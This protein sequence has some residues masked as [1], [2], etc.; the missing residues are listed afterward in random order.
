MTLLCSLGIGCFEPANVK[1]NV[2]EIERLKSFEYI[3]SLLEAEEMAR[4]RLN[5]GW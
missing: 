2:E 4:K 3:G 1:V 5:G